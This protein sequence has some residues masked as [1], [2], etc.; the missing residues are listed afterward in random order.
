MK[1]PSNANLY[2]AINTSYDLNF[3][4]RKRKPGDDDQ[5]CLILAA[6]NKSKKKL[7]SLV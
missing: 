2:Y 1:F 6:G 7:L 5:K 3:I 4:L